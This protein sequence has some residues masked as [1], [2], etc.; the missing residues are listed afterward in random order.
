M[1]Q[2]LLLPVLAGVAAGLVVALVFILI[3]TRTQRVSATGILA[4][5]RPRRSGSGRTRLRDARPAKSEL[6][7][8]ARMEAVKLREDLDREIQRRREECERLD[9]R[10]EE[11]ARRPGAEARGARGPRARAASSARRPSRGGSRRS[12][13]AKA[14][15]I[16][17]AQEQRLKLERIAGLS[18]EDARRE[19]LQRV[20]DEARA[21]AAALARDI[22]EQ[23][24]RGADRDARRI[25]SMAI[26]RLA[27][28]HTAESTVVRGGA[29]QRRDEG[30]DHRPRGPEHPRLRD[31]DRRRRHHRRH[32]GHGD[33]VLLRPDPARGGPPLAGSADP[34]R[35]DPSGPN[36]G[37]R[38]QGAE[39]AR[40][41]AGRA[42]RAGGLRHRASTAS[43]RS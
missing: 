19:I 26:Q 12:A 37:G 36:R 6:L 42:G 5:A 25:I 38:R 4:T 16:G 14:R 13:R 15:P 34:R 24:A 10:A 7:V 31:R 20:E 23:A 32:A 21:Q 3:Y 43:T 29:A 9:R 33:R 35:P 2:T 28:E 39:G 30:A 11:R 40:G 18:A 17:L 27:A 1:P 41:A 22:K 8:A